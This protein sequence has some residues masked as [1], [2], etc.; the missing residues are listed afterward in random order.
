M[1]RHTVLFRLSH[2]AG[3]DAESAFLRDARTLAAIPGVENFEQLR[4]LTGDDFDYSFSMEFSDQAA[5]TGYNE[6]PDHVAFVQ[7]RWV[8]EVAAFL[9]IDYAPL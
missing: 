2:P 5:Y 1:I 9:E 6:H 4:V 7:G 8:P 3:S